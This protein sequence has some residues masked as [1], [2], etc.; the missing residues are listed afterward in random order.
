MKKKKNSETKQKHSTFG[1][2]RLKRAN[3]LKGSQ[4]NANEWE[5]GQME[6]KQANVF[7]LFFICTFQIH[8]LRERTNIELILTTN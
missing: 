5:R 2:K 1:E 7:L 6:R 3:P 4:I 8:L